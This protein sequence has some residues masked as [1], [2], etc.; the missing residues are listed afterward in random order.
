M[1]QSYI[2]L[3]IFIFFNVLIVGNLLAE[4]KSSPEDSVKQNRT[5]EFLKRLIEDAKSEAIEELTK[6]Q[7]QQDSQDSLKSGMDGLEID[8]LIINETKTKIG[9]DFYEFF[10]NSWEAPQAITGFSLIISERPA[11]SMGSWVWID[12]DETTV[13]QNRLTPKP[14]E[15]EVAASG[16]VGIVSTYLVNKQNDQQQLAGDEMAGTGIY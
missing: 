1:K 3:G 6:K 2:I 13:Y 8:G 10:Y 7:Q 14:D 4:E 5:Q 9:Q 16:A 12:V 11:G 15:I